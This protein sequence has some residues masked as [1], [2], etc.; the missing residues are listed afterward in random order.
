MTPDQ[1]LLL[2]E[3]LGEDD[4]GP[5]W[6]VLSAALAADAGFQAD[7][8]A[9]RRLAVR[10][11]AL[12]PQPDLAQRVRLLIAGRR[13]SQRIRIG[14][15][16]RARMI[17]RRRRGWWPLVLAAGLILALTAW[18]MA[19]TGSSDAVVDG[20]VAAEGSA[21]G[22]PSA[23]QVVWTDG[24]RADLAPGS[25]A[26]LSGDGLVMEHGAVT[27]VIAPR[28]ARPFRI[29]TPH[30]EVSVLG[31]RFSL[32]LDPGGAV[33]SVSE[34]QVAA[35][36]T[37][38]P[39]GSRARL[40]AGVVRPERLLWGWPE[41]GQ[42][43]IGT[44]DGA[45][46]H[47]GLWTA[48]GGADPCLRIDVGDAPWRWRPGLALV[49]TIR[50]PGGRPVLLQCLNGAQGRN[51]AVESVPVAGDGWQRMRWDLDGLRPYVTGP[52]IAPGDPVI[53]FLLIRSADAPPFAVSAIEIAGPP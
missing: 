16:V 9:H 25:A 8:I 27:C 13:P 45:V 41:R 26:T 22:G 28:P 42:V 44:V 52:G 1:E 6:A 14:R 4:G 10:L 31:T 17:P 33:L 50:A 43:D 23:Q 36:G 3:A 21:L 53:S 32:A 7:W 12:R 24:S 19:A 40:H 39:A 35:G 18:M 38:W 47:S 11:A 34:G 15:A 49:A 48:E 30:G 20:R 51:V 46:A 29:T 37:R 5:G 2:E